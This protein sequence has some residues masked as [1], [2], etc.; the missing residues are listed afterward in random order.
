MLLGH[1]DAN[2]LTVSRSTFRKD[3]RGTE[4]MLM[5]FNVSLKY[6]LRHKANV[7]QVEGPLGKGVVNLH[8]VKP[9]TESE[10]IYKYL[11]LD[12]KG[13]QR[14]YMENADAT[15]DSPARNKSKMFGVAWR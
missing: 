7:C 9:P 3:Q 8:M 1:Y 10:F 6:M 13:H 12:V 2:I 11:A 4:H 5:H 15:S 14:I